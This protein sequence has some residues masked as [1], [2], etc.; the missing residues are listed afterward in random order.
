MVQ[1]TFDLPPETLQ[2]LERAATERGT[3]VSEIMQLAIADMLRRDPA[4][5][6]E[7]EHR[8]AELQARVQAQRPTGLTPEQVEH[9]ID[10]ATQEIWAEK[11]AARSR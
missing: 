5:R 6:R 2:A 10:A 3:T 4:T 7:W 1:A 9:E 8:W 11:R